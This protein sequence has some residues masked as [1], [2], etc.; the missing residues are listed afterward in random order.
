MTQGSRPSHIIHFQRWGPCDDESS[1]CCAMVFGV[2]ASA[3]CV[4]VVPKNYLCGGGNPLITRSAQAVAKYRWSRA[5]L[6]EKVGTA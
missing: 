3:R 5:M 6:M 2:P 4:H 1:Q